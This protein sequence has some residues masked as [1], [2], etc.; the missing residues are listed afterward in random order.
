MRGRG[1]EVATDCK[2]LGTV[3]GKA[4]HGVSLSSSSILRLFAT[5][6]FPMLF[7]FLIICLCPSYCSSPQIV[8]QIEWL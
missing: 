1:K 3:F 5:Y 7:L 8:L 4:D 6:C 2:S